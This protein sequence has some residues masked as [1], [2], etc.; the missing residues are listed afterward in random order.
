MAIAKSVE[1]KDIIDKLLT[2][3]HTTIYALE[4]VAKLGNKT[5]AS[6]IRRN[7]A[8]SYDTASKINK[9][10]PDVRVEWLRTGE[11]DMM[12]PTLSPS[13]SAKQMHG[14]DFVRQVPFEAFMVAHVLIREARAGY[15]GA[16][17]D[18]HYVEKLPMMLVPR[19]YDKGNYLVIEAVG[20]SMDDGTQRAICDGDKLL[21][22]EIENH[23]W[24]KNLQI[25]R[26]VYIISTKTE[27]PVVKQISEVDQSKKMIV[28]HSWND[29][30]DNYPV[31]FDDIDRLFV[32]K[33]IVERQVRI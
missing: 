18:P 15:M 14:A 3:K 10:Y 11:G 12:E 21:V 20:D 7:S 33:K 2:T 25:R 1:T 4:K 9:A 6:A 31:S 24:A 8:L 5:I 30:F 27:A 28:C 22:K 13:P 19:E 26:H 17:G 32:V 23:Q 16:Q 29:Q